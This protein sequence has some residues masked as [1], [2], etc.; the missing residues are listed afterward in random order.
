VTVLASVIL[1]VNED[2]LL[3]V[4]TRRVVDVEKFRRDGSHEQDEILQAAARGNAL[5][6]SLGYNLAMA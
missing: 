5:A 2:L 1:V 3:L 6:Y 4:K